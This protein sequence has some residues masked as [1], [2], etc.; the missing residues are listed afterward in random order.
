ME[1]SQWIAKLVIIKLLATEHMEVKE[2]VVLTVYQKR[3]FM[4]HLKKPEDYNLISSFFYSVMCVCHCFCF[5]HLIQALA[6]FFCELKVI[7]R[8]LCLFEKIQTLQRN[9]LNFRVYE[10]TFSLCSSR[11]VIFKHAHFS[12]SLLGYCA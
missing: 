7:L 8:S 5:I 11:N 3:Y 10:F 2:M 1:G 4:T 9:T 6:F 12:I